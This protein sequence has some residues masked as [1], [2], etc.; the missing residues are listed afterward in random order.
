MISLQ[1]PSFWP[2][3]ALLVEKENKT[4]N[5]ADVIMSK[6]VTVNDLKTYSDII[7]YKNEELLSFSWIIYL[8][9]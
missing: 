8:L 5:T 3:W 2:W 4:K 1:I 7:K 6:N 9:Y